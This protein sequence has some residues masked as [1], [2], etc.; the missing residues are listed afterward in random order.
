M[1]VVGLSGR[2]C[3]FWQMGGQDDRWER[4]CRTSA[5][6]AARSRAARHMRRPPPCGLAS[7][8]SAPGSPPGR[9]VLRTAG[10]V[11]VRVGVALQAFLR[12]SLSLLAV[13]PSR[14]CMASTH[15]SQVQTVCLMHSLIGIAPIAFYTR[16][17]TQSL[18]PYSIQ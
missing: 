4:T 10:A 8:S 11:A 3:V 5:F 14:G 1:Q 18:T 2:A 12:P 9:P 15:P 6:Q 13:P 7:L 16:S 17:E